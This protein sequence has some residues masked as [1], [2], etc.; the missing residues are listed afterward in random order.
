MKKALSLILCLSMLLSMIVIPSV[1][2][3][4]K[5]E[6]KAAYAV[7]EE[8]EIVGD[9]VWGET[10]ANLG[11]AKIVDRSARMGVTDLYML[12]KGTG[13][14]LSYLKTQYKDALTRTDR[15]VLQELITAAHAKGIRVHAWLVTVEDEYYKSKHPEAGVYH[16]VRGTD[17]DRINPYDAD[18]RKYMSYDIKI[19]HENK[20]TAY[21]R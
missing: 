10:V 14:K 21:F 3:E 4:E 11:A 12:A 15:D 6:T 20:L 2:A 8:F 13:G 5:A 16:Y 9:W 19:H 18:Y 1:A 17:N 7:Q